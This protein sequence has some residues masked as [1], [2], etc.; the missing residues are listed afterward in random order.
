MQDPNLCVVKSLD[1]YFSRT[2]GLGSA[3]ECY[4]LTLSFVNSHEPTISGWLKNVLRKVRIN[5]GTF[6]A[7]STRPASTS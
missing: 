2:E 6:K 5:I 3:E 7:H 1:E 4:Q